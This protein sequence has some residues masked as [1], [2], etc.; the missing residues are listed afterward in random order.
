MIKAGQRRDREHTCVKPAADTARLARSG[1][2]L[3]RRTVALSVR[4][5][6]VTLGLVAFLLGAAAVAPGPAAFAAGG[7]T[8]WS[9]VPS[10]N[11]ARNGENAL[12][13]VSAGS[14][15]SAWAVGYDGNNGNFR[16]LIERWNGARWAVVPSPSV[17]PLDNVLSGVT[18]LSA[19]SSWAVGY[20]SVNVPPRIYHRAMIEHWNGS[21]WRVV[22]APQAGTSDSDLWGVTALSATN[23]WTVGNVNVGSFQFRPLIEHWT[24]TAWHLVH[25]PS[26]P[27]TGTGASLFGVAATSPGDIWAVGNYA[28]GKRFQPLIEHFNGTRWALIPA[29]VAGSAELNRISL[30]TPSN[31]WAVGLRAASTPAHTQAL[32]EHWNGHHWTVAHTP[33]VPGSSLADVLAL[34]PHL[35]WAVGTA[36]AP[37]GYTSTLIER[38]NGRAW[39]VIPSPNRPPTSELI[40][41]GGTQQRLW[42]VGAARTNTLILRH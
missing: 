8:D 2:R 20:T 18:T 13:Q 16:T 7:S 6:G 31:G 29:P 15:A 23:A 9:I 35:A 17:G 22:P 26:P 19:S 39:T 12:V 3:G 37:H 40:G 38:W 27:L 33:A 41:I 28:V 24:G 1:P 34:S 42:A 21:T 36:A 5:A 32:I 30:L 14:A 11:G 25:A 4:H 10:P